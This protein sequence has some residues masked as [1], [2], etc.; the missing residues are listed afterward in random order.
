[1]Q[2]VLGSIL[3]TKIATKNSEE[4]GMV[5][6]SYNPS[7]LGSRYRRIKVQDKPR[8]KVSKI[9][10]QQNKPGMWSLSII[11]ATQEA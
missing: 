10:S 3:S 4:P 11:L 5:A 1:M 6:H 9:S 7:Y 8:H 2:E